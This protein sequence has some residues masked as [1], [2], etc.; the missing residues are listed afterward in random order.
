MSTG[1]VRLWSVHLLYFLFACIDVSDQS[2]FMRD[3]VWD[4]GP[5]EQSSRVTM[6]SSSPADQGM[7]SH[8][9]NTLGSA[10]SRISVF[11]LA[12]LSRTLT[13]VSS[14][15]NRLDRVRY[16]EYTLQEWGQKIRDSTSLCSAEIVKVDR[17]VQKTMIPHRFLVFQLRRANKSRDIFLRLDR[18]PV[19]GIGFILRLGVTP[20]NDCVSSILKR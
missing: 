13:S 5:S 9:V 17:Y 11:G 4:N 3:D 10:R 6:T 20:A 18:R 7:P 8:Q 2:E 15:S 1:T 19:R 16:W 14:W 12:P